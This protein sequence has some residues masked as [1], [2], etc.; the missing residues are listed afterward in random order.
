[1]ARAADG[2][3]AIL[4]TGAAGLTGS[5]VIRQLC[6]RHMPAR[7]LVRDPSRASALTT[8]P[9]V[10]VVTGDL[11]RPETLSQALAG[12]QRAML[13]S[14]ADAAMAQVQSSFIDA[15]ADAGVSQIVKLSGIMPALDSRREFGVACST[16][17]C[18][19]PVT[20]VP[21]ALSPARPLGRHARCRKRG[22]RR[23]VACS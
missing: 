15:A 8:L 12:V 4:V 13:I 7:A 3:T 19:R 21:A 9:G 10:E 14:S 16:N 20:T 6:D 18:L 5:Q 11:G 17:R 2:T 22:W 23:S 1:L